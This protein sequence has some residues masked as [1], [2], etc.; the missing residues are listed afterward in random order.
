MS[1]KADVHLVQLRNS[2]IRFCVYRPTCPGQRAIADTVDVVIVPVP[3]SRAA[4]IQHQG[5]TGAECTHE[6]GILEACQVIAAGLL[7]AGLRAHF[8]DSTKDKPGAPWC[9]D[10]DTPARK[11]LD[12]RL[13]SEECG[14]A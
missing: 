8:D 10:W 5:D 13:L 1:I 14:A 9:A 12:A 3:L 11:H 6:S 7:D 2:Y 4:I